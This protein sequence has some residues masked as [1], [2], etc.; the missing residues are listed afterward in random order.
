[1]GFPGL[2]A[3]SIDHTVTVS[4]PSSLTEEQYARW[5]KENGFAE[6]RQILYWIW[7]PI[8]VNT[9]FPYTHDEYDRYAKVLLSKLRKGASASDVVDYLVSVEKGPMGMTRAVDL[10]PLGVRVMEWYEES[11]PYWLDRQT[12]R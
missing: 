7:D 6:L 12:F 5:W 8:G 10:T 2:A 3:A 4:A 1:M 11:I 9:A